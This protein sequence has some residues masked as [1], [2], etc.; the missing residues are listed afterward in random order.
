MNLWRKRYEYYGILAS[1]R[2]VLF[3]LNAFDTKNEHNEIYY[4]IEPENLLNV[5]ISLIHK[6][7]DYGKLI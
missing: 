2:Y 5:N 7:D 4:V 6:N 3:T 1:D